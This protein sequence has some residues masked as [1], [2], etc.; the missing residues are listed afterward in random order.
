MKTENKKTELKK[1]LIKLFEN[2]TEI[3][4]NF[5]SGIEADTRQKTKHIATI[6]DFCNTY[7][8]YYVLSIVFIGGN[9]SEYQTAI[10]IELEE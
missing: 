7:F 10:K 8:E 2:C 6:K 9:T 4:K 5:V 1:L 3:N